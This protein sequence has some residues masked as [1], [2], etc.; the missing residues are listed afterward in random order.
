MRHP[1]FLKR[2]LLVG[3][4]LIAG[5]WLKSEENTQSVAGK[6]SERSAG[7]FA[8][9]EELLAH[10]DATRDA[11]QPAVAA[12][13]YRAAA[14]RRRERADLW[15]QFGNMLKD[16][17]QFTEAKAAYETALELRET[18][19]T[20]L[21]FGHLCK[22]FGYREQARFQYEKARELDPANVYAIN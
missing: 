17:N 4:K 20:H 6:N 15:V 10:A 3:Q 9:F 16:S 13:S 1:R 12:E 8:S 2:I 22:Q 11:G 14:R 18:S 5:E 21:Q 7:D 19:D